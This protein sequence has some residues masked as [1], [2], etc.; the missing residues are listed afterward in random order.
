MSDA[1]K[2]VQ[3]AIGHLVESGFETGI[4]VAAYW[5]GELVVDAGAGLADADFSTA[6]HITNVVTKALS[7]R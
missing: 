1:Q 2:Q 3:A 6:A 5:H 4:Q 7:E